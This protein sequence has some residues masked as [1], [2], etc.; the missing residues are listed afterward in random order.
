[1]PSS[2]PLLTR[3]TTADAF[4][5]IMLASALCSMSIIEYTIPQLTRLSQSS[6]SPL[7]HIPFRPRMLLMSRNLGPQTAITV[8][9]FG[10]VRE[11]RDVLDLTLGP[12]RFNV[13]L[14]YGAA[15]VP[16]IAAK[17]NLIQESVLRHSKT[18]TKTTNAPTKKLPLHTQALQFWSHKIQ[19]G[20]LWSYLRDSGSIGGGIVLGPVVTSLV[21][22]DVL[23][24]QDADICPAHRFMGGLLAGS[25]TGLATQ[26]F[27]NTAL[28]GGRIAQ[29]ESRA[30][31]T[32]ECLRTVLKEQGLAAL[33]MNF[34]MRVMIIATWTAILNVTEPFA[35]E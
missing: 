8:V 17:Y 11:L 18:K 30:P 12:S 6:S 28:T 13:S 7:A 26:L 19:P 21:M 3:L 14:A 1:M 10:L 20:L 32:M 22:S 35:T 5:Q 29:V 23:Q 4:P 25:G 2:P 34:R 27:H 24:L 16:F 9:Q 31:S 33:W 15:S